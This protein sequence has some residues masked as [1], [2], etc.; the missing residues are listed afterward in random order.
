VATWSTSPTLSAYSCPP[1][2]SPCSDT[3]ATGSRSSLTTSPR[4]NSRTCTATKSPSRKTFYA[5]L[6][7]TH[8][9]VVFGR[10]QLTE[11]IFATVSVGSSA[12]THNHTAIHIDV[13]ETQ[14]DPCLVLRLY[15]SDY[16]YPLRVSGSASDDDGVEVKMAFASSMRELL[17]TGVGGSNR[18][19]VEDFVVALRRRE[20][21]RFQEFIWVFD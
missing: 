21:S 16:A 1:V 4:A 18:L 7:P 10:Y 2:T 8:T 19:I 12:T 17:P 15:G 11:G 5:L 14:P 9:G 20:H 13:D 3:S 6:T